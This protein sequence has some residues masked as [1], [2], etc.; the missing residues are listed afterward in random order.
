LQFSSVKLI[1]THDEFPEG[2][3]IFSAIGNGWPLVLSS[4]KKFHA[5][6]GLQLYPPPA[7]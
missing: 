5:T 3:Q 7:S 2:T 6:H 4:L 1:V